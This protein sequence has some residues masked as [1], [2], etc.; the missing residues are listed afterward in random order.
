MTGYIICRRTTNGR[1]LAQFHNNGVVG[2]GPSK[3]AAVYELMLALVEMGK[4][5]ITI[6]A[7]HFEE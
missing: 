6:T 5:P 4:F 3:Q 1:Y 2:G 7:I